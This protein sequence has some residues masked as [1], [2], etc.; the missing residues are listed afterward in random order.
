MPVDPQK[1]A[2]RAAVRARLAQLT[3]N[4][5]HPTLAEMNDVLGQMERAEGSSVVAGVN[6][7]AVRT[8]LVQVEKLRR[9]GKALQA[10]AQKP[11][12]GD[13]QK[14]HELMRQMQQVEAQMRYDV[15]AAPPSTSAL[16]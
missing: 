2:A 16:R 7:E 3:A 15:S 9:L 10:E 6:L 4:G 12:G 1:T 8:N 13:K 5:R 11:G 14:L